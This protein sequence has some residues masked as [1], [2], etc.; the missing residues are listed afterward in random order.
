MVAAMVH[1]GA[2]EPFGVD[3]ADL[4]FAIVIRP[5]PHGDR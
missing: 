3:H 2:V 5:E 1:E 4:G